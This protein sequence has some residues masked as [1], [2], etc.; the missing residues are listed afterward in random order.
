MKAEILTIGDEILIG[1]ISNTNSVWIAQQLTLLGIKIIHM[2]SIADRED[3]ILSAFNIALQ[4]SDFV[5]ITGGLGPTKDD[6]TK[7]SFVKF[8]ETK[9]TL[10]KETL[11]DITRIF[12]KKGRK[13]GPLNEHQAL[14]PAGCFVIKNRNG[15]APGMWMQKDKTVFISL[16]GVPHEMKAMMNETVLPKIRG[17]NHLPVI[18]HKTV[19]TQGIAESSLAEMIENWENQL[20]ASNITLAYLPQSGMV[21]LRLSTIGEDLES[22][23]ASVDEEV[24]KL[25]GIIERFIY[26]YEIYGEDSPTLEKIVSDLL[27]S[28]KK[29]LAL[30]ESCS[31]GYIASLITAI[32]GASEIFRGAIVPYSN[33]AKNELLEV[34]PIVFETEGAVSKTCV[35]Q[36]ALNVLKKLNS[37]FSIAVSGIAGPT[38]AT[39]EKPVGLV[40]IAIATRQKV[41]ASKFVFGNDRQQ[42]IVMTAQAA[43]NLLRKIIL[44]IP[45]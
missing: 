13:P 40:W 2:S 35:E 32:P 3:D 19:L 27:R 24:K 34:D 30:A 41:T 7:A 45:V 10:H 29:T 6:L 42:N 16:P 44:D 36:L 43:L 11:E 23:K 14:V 22:L 37:D 21:R 12:G 18:Y 17:E 15:T 33:Q 38:G 4:R 39:A 26:G 25:K 20:S 28:Q 5:F 31:G 8:F 1:Q 9:L